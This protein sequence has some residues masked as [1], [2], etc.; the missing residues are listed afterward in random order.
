MAFL[1]ISNDAVR[2][3]IIAYLQAATK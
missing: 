1:G 2:A 3:N